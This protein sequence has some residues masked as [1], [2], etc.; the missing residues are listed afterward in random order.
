[1]SLNSKDVRAWAAAENYPVATRG[2]VPVE[3]TTEYL[4]AHSAD[5]RTLGD[6]LDLDIPGRG[7]VSYETCERIAR[8]L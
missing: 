8:S 6:Q 7:R 3:V 2:R 1:V 5:A 4:Y